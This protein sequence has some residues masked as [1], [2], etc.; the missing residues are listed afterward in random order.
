MA[1]KL[2]DDIGLLGAGKAPVGS[3]RLADDLGL[4]GAAEAPPIPVTGFEG[5]EPTPGEFRPLATV[6]RR[7]VQRLTES[8]QA[9]LDAPAAL[10]GLVM[11]REATPENLVTG[12]QPPGRLQD[13]FTVLRAV[14]SPFEPIFAPIGASLQTSA[15]EFGA[16]PEAAQLIGAGG[17]MA[18]GLALPFIRT[19]PTPALGRPLQRVG[20]GRAPEATLEAERALAL[21][22]Q[23]AA[24]P[25][26][27][28]P[29]V[30]DLGLLRGG[31]AAQPPPPAVRPTPGGPALTPD[32][33]TVVEKG[34]PGSGL[35]RLELE[36]PTPISTEAVKSFFQGFDVGVTKRKGEIGGRNL[37]RFDVDFF[38][39]EGRISSGEL[40]RA[41]Q[42]TGLSIQPRGGA[43]I[44][45]Q[46]PKTKPQAEPL[47]AGVTQEE[48]FDR[49]NAIRRTT[50]D[51]RSGAEPGRVVV[52]DPESLERGIKRPIGAVSGQGKIL[53]LVGEVFDEVSAV[54]D[55]SPKDLLD[56]I[57]RDKENPTYVRLKQAVADQLLRE[58]G[59]EPAAAPTAPPL[60]PPAPPPVEPQLL[61]LPE[62]VEGPPPAR[63]AN[64]NLARIQTPDDVKTLIADVARA[65]RGGI[66][67]ARRGVITHAETARLADTIGLTPEKLLKRR[68]GKAFNAEEALASRQILTQSAEDTWELARAAREGGEGA[69]TDF[70]L[71]LQRH[72]ALQKQVSGLTAEAGR[73][74]SAMR[75]GAESQAARGR[76][77]KKVVEAIGGEEKL[78]EEIID[79]L[80]KL[81]PN[82]PTLARDVNLFVRDISEAKTGDK[83]FEVWVNSL[84]SGPITHVVNTVSNS[85][86]ALSRPVLERPTAATIDFFRAKVTGTERQRFFGEAAAD[87]FGMTRSMR[88][89]LRKGLEA[90]QM[91]LGSFGVTKLEIAPAA[92]TAIK[93][94]TG[95]IVR[96]PGRALIAADEFFKTVNFQG[97]LNAL[98]YR[99]A[100]REGRTGAARAYRIA[101]IIR[102]PSSE[103]LEKAEA[104][105]LYRVFQAELG[106]IGQQLRALRN[107]IPGVRYI[108]PFLRTPINIVKYGLERT[109]LNF[110]RLAAKAKRGELA[111][112]ALADELA[113]PV[114]G[115][116]I[117]AGIA[118][119]ASEG[120]I[121]GG[122]PRDPARRRAL[123][124]TGWQP[125]SVKVGDQW[126]SYGRLEPLGIV[127]GL[128]ADYVELFDTLEQEDAVSKISLAIA[129]NLTNKTFLRGISDLVNAASDPE[130]YG[131]RWVRGLTGTV[132]PTGVAQLARAFD[133]TLRRPETAL[134]GLQAR[135]PIL[136]FQVPA[137]RDIWGQPTLRQ[138]TGFERFLSPIRRSPAI[139]DKAS[140][141][142][143]RLDVRPGTPRRQ[144]GRVEL[145][146]AE[147]E[148]YAELAG[149][150]ARR[151]VTGFVESP[152]YDRLPDTIKAMKIEDLFNKA[153][154]AAR[155]AV[156]GEALPRILREQGQPGLLRAVSPLG[157][158]V[159]PERG[160]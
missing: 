104:E 110:L 56:A 101:E 18:A 64:I 50:E 125:Y 11:G 116:L 155:L 139:Q 100:A 28:R 38:D 137:I 33:I 94:R 77:F 154:A 67:E 45:K 26:V 81:D 105:T 151:M 27:A 63:A 37:Q 72:I 97:E 103:L 4:L 21:G 158:L 35:L 20:I 142:L 147:Y 123:F 96:I 73:T 149:T 1:R 70:L 34:G 80:S 46:A 6:G 82:S 92:Q 19:A 130:R 108:V 41:L 55:V 49:I 14:A 132:I 157:E 95:R 53:D 2:A 153:R 111:G 3:R 136:S 117:A 69:K 30:D 126:V 23:A 40:N 66:E 93:G 135:T 98:A 134:Q 8:G 84:L 74:L 99:Q 107:S 122:G 109:P 54:S 32:V 113:K 44:P 86:T 12:Q 138:E 13:L 61:G 118:L 48:V 131:E 52:F 10:R 47:P 71:G 119:L 62:G 91:E 24:I 106:P 115:S 58:K 75:I 127:V 159:A 5:F 88:E 87:I 124:T 160:R 128:T 156:K 39:A 148:R 140:Q 129:Q 76:A 145:S 51:F 36:S 121:S 57:K 7:T 17:E 43:P 85:L 102:N 42:E 114:M 143:V 90:Y 22:R 79:R 112:V 31:E 68:L 65:N 120:L 133:P 141:E 25:R 150:L 60:R 146:P 78:T 59:L 16:T 9:V 89:G 29:L 144:L 15:E 152:G 83:V